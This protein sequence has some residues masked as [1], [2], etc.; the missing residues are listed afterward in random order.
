MAT[1]DTPSPPSAEDIPL[2]GGDGPLLLYDGSCGFC[3]R[4]VQFVLE[5]EGR[6]RTMCF[7]ALESRVG[8]AVRS[9][10]PE[11]AGVDSVIWYEPATATRPDRVLV[12]SSAAL[13]VARY[14]GGT[15]W[16]LGVLGWLVPRVIRDAVYDRIARHR[17]EIASQAC[18]L[19]T[20]D[21]RA[22]FLDGCT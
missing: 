15:W 17:L 21:Q 2:R 12:R 13:A 18:M 20:P 14:L 11:L 22:R 9:R 19:P 1:T 8:K 6:R 10:C 5:H 3:A 4:S 7:A 16:V